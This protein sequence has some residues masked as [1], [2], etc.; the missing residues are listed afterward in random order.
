M[1]DLLNSALHVLAQV[2]DTVAQGA[3]AV[4][5]GADA[6]TQGAGT[7]AQ[8]AGTALQS[9]AAAAPTTAGPLAAE[10]APDGMLHFISQSDMVGKSLFGILVFM[11]LISWYLIFV[12]SFTNM[13]VHRRSNKF[14]REFWAASSLDEVENEIAT[15]G[16]TEPF[17]HLAS[18]AIHAQKHHAKYG[19]LKLEEK[20]STGAF[21]TRTIRKVIDEE[22][23]K[24]E[25]G[26]TVLASVG[27]TAPFVGLFGTVWGV[28]HALVGI[29][30]SVD[31]VTIN[32]IAGP[33]GEA[34]IM[35]GLGLAVAIPA[36]L[37]Y[38]GFVRSNRVYLAKLDAFAHDL[39]TF[40]ST[41]QQAFEWNGKG[42]RM[43]VA[44][45]KG[46]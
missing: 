45:S 24:F 27:S 34:L 44:T 25:N 31:G 33:V 18:H 7:V 15:H 17:A 11:S 36:V 16:A 3:D 41:G 40:L 21:V 46:N 26:L 2:S 42:R 30:L 9:G 35:T 8:D 6:V 13:R 23:A 22:T 32:R 37:A 20:G 39:F 38:N 1:F 14:L 10:A 4:M 28:Y 12:K 43:A 19:A 5:Q 29:G